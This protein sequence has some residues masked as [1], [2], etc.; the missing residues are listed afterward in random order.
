MCLTRAISAV[1]EDCACPISVVDTD[2]LAT[3][4][5]VCMGALAVPNT[6]GHSQFGLENPIKFSKKPMKSQNFIGGPNEILYS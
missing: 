6:I 4:Y 1:L 5:L 2:S 3:K